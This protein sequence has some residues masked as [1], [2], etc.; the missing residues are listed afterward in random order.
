MRGQETGLYCYFED[1]FTY[2]NVPFGN[3]AYKFEVVL[4]DEGKDVREITDRLVG[5]LRE[6]NRMARE[7]S[8]VTLELP[9]FSLENKVGLN[10]A[11]RAGGLK[12]LDKFNP[13]SLFT[14]EKTGLIQFNQ[15]VMFEVDEKGAKAVAVSSGEDIL[16]SP[17]PDPSEPVEIKVNRPFLFFITERSTGVCLVA[18]RVTD[19]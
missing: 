8:K 10:S 12:S 18:G 7:Y 11:L 6:I 16:S 17:G 14:E 15:S 4:P 1:G 13:L 9:K 19:L 3:A 5:S 2:V